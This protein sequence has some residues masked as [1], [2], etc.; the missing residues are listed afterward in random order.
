MN[1]PDSPA[2]RYIFGAGEMADHIVR[3]L[4]STGKPIDQ[5]EFFDDAFPARTSGPAGLPIVA[6]FAE[7]MKLS[8]HDREPV[9]I[10]TGSKGAAVRYSLLSRLMLAG[11]PLASAIHP[12]L[13][14]GP[15]ACIGSH[16][17]AFPGC[18]IGK[19]VEIESWCWFYSGVIIE[20]DAEVGNNVIFG[21]GVV[22]AGN[23]RIGR[24]AFLGA[25]V[26]VAPGVTIG[27]RSILGAGAVVVRDIPPG[28]IAMGVPASVRR[29]VP[30]GADAPTLEALERLGC[31]E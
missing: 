24:H 3:L 4:E 12:S 9:M 29:P 22:I 14:I 28:M 16:L 5:I 7:G 11:V 21:P 2:P 8:L 18:I 19:N 25:G 23:V 13:S 6:N 15:G 30:E 20:H 10:A 31:L 17:V 26:T 27:E 1:A